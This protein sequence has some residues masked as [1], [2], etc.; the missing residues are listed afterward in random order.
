MIHPNRSKV[1]RVSGNTP[2]FDI[3][4]IDEDGVDFVEFGKDLSKE[5]KLIVH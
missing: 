2:I 1:I 3:R 5:N 4:I